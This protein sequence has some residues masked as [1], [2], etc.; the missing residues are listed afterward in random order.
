MLR[1]GLGILGVVS[2]LFFPWYITAII[3]FF[4]F[5]KYNWYGEGIMLALISDVLYG[6]ELFGN[7]FGLMLT[8]LSLVGLLLVAFIKTR[9][10]R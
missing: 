8:G 1:F 6:T 3:I 10:L 7:S 5:F 9:L 2:T 4:G